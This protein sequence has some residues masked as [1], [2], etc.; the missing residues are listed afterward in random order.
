MS[1]HGPKGSVP[2]VEAFGLLSADWRDRERSS[3]ALLGS[4]LSGMSDRA[5]VTIRITNFS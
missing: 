5:L 1:H 4:S 2:R 3:I